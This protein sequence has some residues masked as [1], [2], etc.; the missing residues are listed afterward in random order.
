[1]FH[2]AAHIEFCFGPSHFENC[3]IT[4]SQDNPH[5]SEGSFRIVRRAYTFCATSTWLFLDGMGPFA[6]DVLPQ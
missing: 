4:I 6:S 1:M 5:V 2:I 3:H